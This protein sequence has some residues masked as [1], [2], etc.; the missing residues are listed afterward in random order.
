MCFGDTDEFV[1][2]EFALGRPEFVIAQSGFSAQR[3]CFLEDRSVPFVNHLLVVNIEP[4]SFRG[5]SEFITYKL[6]DHGIG[7]DARAG[8]ALSAV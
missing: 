5:Q 7:S 8:D 3:G 2:E 1:L 6:G 4:A